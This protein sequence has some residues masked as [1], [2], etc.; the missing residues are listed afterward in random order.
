MPKNGWCDHDAPN[1][2]PG[3]RLCLRM[4]DAITMPR[5]INQAFVYAAFLPV[6]KLWCQ[7][8][9]KMFLKRPTHSVI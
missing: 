4:D 5:I 6:F 8:W 1:N 3:V 2:Q 9:Q 7:T